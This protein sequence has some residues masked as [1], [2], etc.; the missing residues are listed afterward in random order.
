MVIPQDREFFH[1]LPPTPKKNFLNNPKIFNPLT[2]SSLVTTCYNLT[3][4]LQKL[5]YF[6]NIASFSL[7]VYA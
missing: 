4:L 6:K 1:A 7:L 2:I 3:T 5:G